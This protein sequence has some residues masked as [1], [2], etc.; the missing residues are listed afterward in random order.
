MAVVERCVVD[1]TVIL[2]CYRWLFLT[3]VLWFVNLLCL[4]DSIFCS[5]DLFSLAVDLMLFFARRKNGCFLMKFYNSERKLYGLTWVSSLARRHV[6]LTSTPRVLLETKPSGDFWGL[7]FKTLQIVLAAHSLPLS[8]LYD[9]LIN[10]RI[11]VDEH[12]PITFRQLIKLSAVY[13]LGLRK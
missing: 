6:F 13:C 1:S 9:W 8:L 10:I 4:C 2:I 11:A 12:A 5:L 7:V 3:P